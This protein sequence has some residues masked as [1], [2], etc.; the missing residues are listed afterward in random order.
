MIHRDLKSSNILMD[1]GGLRWLISVW[2][3]G[4]VVRV[5]NMVGCL[6]RNLANA[7]INTEPILVQLQTQ[8]RG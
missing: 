1:G 4:M 8:K 7:N 2:R 3:G 5:G 6:V